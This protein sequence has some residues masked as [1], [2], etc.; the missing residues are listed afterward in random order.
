MMQSQGFDAYSLGDNLLLKAAE[1]AAKYN[2][3]NDVPYDPKFYRCEAILING[4]WSAPS[5]ISRGVGWLTRTSQ[6]TM[7]WDILY[8]Q[9]VVKRGLPAPWT[10]Q[11]KKAFDAAGGE[12]HR[13]CQDSEI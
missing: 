6:T 11:A 8:Y 5:P 2:L 7:V 13:K 9:Y 10:I 4:P 1:Y 3:G 12:Q